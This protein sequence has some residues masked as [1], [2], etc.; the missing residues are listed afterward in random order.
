MKIKYMTSKRFPWIFKSTKQNT[1]D[2]HLE[3][4]Y[5]FCL[6]EGEGREKEECLCFVRKKPWIK[7]ILST[8]RI[9]SAQKKNKQ[10]IKFWY[11]AEFLNY[12]PISRIIICCLHLRKS[13]KDTQTPFILEEGP[14]AST[15][16][17]SLEHFCRVPIWTLYAFA[18]DLNSFCQCSS[19]K[20]TFLYIELGPTKFWVTPQIH[21][22]LQNVA[23]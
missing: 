2:G 11:S 21:S 8:C 10:N 6:Q 5:W 9:T 16:N 17:E 22:F 3:K 14:V 23:S 7:R 20:I 13:H 1:S 18:N 12:R 19:M 4:K 15:L